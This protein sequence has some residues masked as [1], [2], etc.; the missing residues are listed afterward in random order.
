[1]QLLSHLYKR[2]VSLSHSTLNFFTLSWC[3]C[4]EL[5]APHSLSLFLRAFLPSFIILTRGFLCFPLSKSLSP[6]SFFIG[7]CSWDLGYFMVTFFSL[8]SLGLLWFSCS[9]L[10][11]LTISFYRHHIRFR[12]SVLL[13]LMLNFNTPSLAREK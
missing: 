13:W 5:F 8:V 2:D 10:S 6:L 12:Y 9:P 1:M 4:I 11:F 3:Y 7:V